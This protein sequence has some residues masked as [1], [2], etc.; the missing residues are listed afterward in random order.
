MTPR[1]VIGFAFTVL[2]LAWLV[3]FG[4]FSFFYSGDTPD[5]AHE[6][7]ALL[8]DFLGGTLTPVLTFLTIIILIKS[9][10]LQRDEIEKNKQFEKVRS[11]ESHFFNM[12]ESQKSLFNG[13]RLTFEA[14]GTAV[15]KSAGSAVVALED[16]IVH[17]K[18]NG[19]SN[20]EISFFLDEL[21]C[22]DSIYSAIRTFA[23]ITKLIDKKLSAESG[24]NENERKEYLEILLNYTDFS[25]IRLVLVSMK[26]MNNPQLLALKDSREFLEVLK[27]IG[28]SSYLDEI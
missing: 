25:L 9:L 2:V 1:K 12:I 18:D 7:W 23:V 19:K 13:F 10:A 15:T 3:Y 22:D 6:Q 24:F 16:I 11:F 4:Y 26:Y 5:K 17:L 21:D 20:D 8:G 14:N 28:I 27:N